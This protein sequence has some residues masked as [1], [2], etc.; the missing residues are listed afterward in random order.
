MSIL[1]YGVKIWSQTK[2]D[3]STETFFAYVSWLK[4]TN[5]SRTISAPTTHLTSRPTVATM[6]FLRSTVGK[7]RRRKKENLKIKQNIMIWECLKNE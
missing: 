6:R 7:N 4:M 3:I 5:V 1:T 2:A